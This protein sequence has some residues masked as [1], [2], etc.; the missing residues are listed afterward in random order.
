MGLFRLHR[1][2]VVAKFT[3]GADGTGHKGRTA[4]WAL[5]EGRGRSEFA[6]RAVMSRRRSQ[7]SSSCG[8]CSVT[9]PGQSSSLWFHQHRLAQTPIASPGASACSTWRSQEWRNEQPL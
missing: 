7:L 4:P 8:N 6:E 1:I 3:N 2:T 5:T 9:S